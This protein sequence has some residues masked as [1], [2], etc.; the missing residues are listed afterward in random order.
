MTPFTN[1]MHKTKDPLPHFLPPKVICQVPSLAPSTPPSNH[2]PTSHWHMK[3]QH[4]RVHENRK[5]ST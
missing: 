5:I 2:P 4:S 1:T 3:G